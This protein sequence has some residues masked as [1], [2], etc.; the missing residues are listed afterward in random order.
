MKVVNPYYWLCAVIIE[1]E[2]DQRNSV[3]LNN[4]YLVYL[5]LYAC[6][7][8][9][10]LYTYTMY[11]YMIIEPGPTNIPGSFNDLIYNNSMKVLL[12][13]SSLRN[14][15]SINDTILA[16]NEDVSKLCETTFKKAWSFR[17]DLNNIVTLA[18][19]V[20]EIYLCDKHFSMFISG[21]KNVKQCIENKISFNPERQPDCTVW[22]RFAWFYNTKS[23]SLEQVSSNEGSSLYGKLFL[24][25]F[26]QYVVIENND[27]VRFPEIHVWQSF[28]MHYLSGSFNR[29]LSSLV[30]SGIYQYQ[31]QYQEIYAQMIALKGFLIASRFKRTWNW[32]SLV[33]QWTTKYKLEMTESYSTVKDF[34]GGSMKDFRYVWMFFAL[35]MLALALLFLLELYWHFLVAL[36]LTFHCITTKNL[37]GT[38]TMFTGG[39]IFN[40]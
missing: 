2:S 30:E 31:S 8:I 7:L 18:R 5:W 12:D 25:L 14:F 27:P 29:K 21:R 34:V 37:L 9:R 40:L 23:S 22:N 11:D 6:H 26:E 32:F 17:N 33:S 16:S 19:S 28:K 13:Y 3:T 36:F 39:K 10:S 15:I 24:L 1:Q 35:T 20:N 4:W 38:K